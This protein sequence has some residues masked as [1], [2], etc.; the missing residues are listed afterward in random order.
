MRLKTLVLVAAMVAAPVWAQEGK[1]PHSQLTITSPASGA[2]VAS[3]VTVTFGYQGEGKPSVKPV[4]L[5]VDQALPEQGSDV[6]ADQVHVFKV[7]KAKTGSSELSLTLTPGKHS[8]AIL[9]M[10]KGKA[11]RAPKGYAPVSITVQ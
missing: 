6:A 8:L 9:A 1:Q 2:A 5:F 7:P 4:F 10:S 11:G 3:P